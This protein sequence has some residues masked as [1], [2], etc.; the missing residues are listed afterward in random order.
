MVIYMRHI[1][2]EHSDND[3]EL[4]LDERGGLALILVDVLVV[5]RVPPG[6]RVIEVIDG[7]G[8]IELYL[9]AVAPLV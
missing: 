4:P 6:V 3:R 5:K 8:G 7:L 9:D 2:A 1:E